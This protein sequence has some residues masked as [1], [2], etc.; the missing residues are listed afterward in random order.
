MKFAH[1]LLDQYFAAM[2]H[3]VLK[4]APPNTRFPTFQAECISIF[5]TRLKKAA[6]TT[7]STSVVTTCSDKADQMVSAL[8]HIMQIHHNFDVANLS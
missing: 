4:V 7:V 5:G 6:K 3:N 2:D 1:Q 8:T